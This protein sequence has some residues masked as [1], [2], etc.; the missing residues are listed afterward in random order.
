M[1]EKPKDRHLYY[2][3]VSQV[4]SETIWEPAADVCKTRTGWLL[5]FEL[6]GVLP[7]DVTVHALGSCLTV[8]GMRRDCTVE[9]VCS[10]YSMEISYNRF[11]RTIELPCDLEGAQIGPEFRNGILLVRVSTKGSER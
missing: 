5:K 6:A 7:E 4:E 11:E 10:S 1:R 3:P 8:S 9:E 2:L